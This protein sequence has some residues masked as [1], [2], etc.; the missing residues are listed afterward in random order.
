MFRRPQEGGLRRWASS[1]AEPPA[2]E[3]VRAS[4]VPLGPGPEALALGPLT[5]A[6]SPQVYAASA[7]LSIQEE[8]GAP[9]RPGRN[10]ES[11]EALRR[12]AFTTGQ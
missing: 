4:D 3:P 8:Q 6:H 12:R 11:Q 10:Y 5:P 9:G 2:A 7:R 1:G